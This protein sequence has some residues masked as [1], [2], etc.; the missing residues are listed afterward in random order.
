MLHG[1]QGRGMEARQQST[2]AGH[3][4]QAKTSGDV[5]AAGKAWRMRSLVATQH[6]PGSGPAHATSLSPHNYN[7][8]PVQRHTSRWLC[9]F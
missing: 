9:R 7:P 1:K 3:K 6:R 5:S 8:A 4:Q 2:S